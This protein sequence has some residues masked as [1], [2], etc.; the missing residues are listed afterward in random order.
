MPCPLLPL[1]FLLAQQPCV[2]NGPWPCEEA[3]CPSPSISCERLKHNCHSRFADVW[4]TPPAGFEHANVIDQCP[5]SCGKCEDKP[6]QGPASERSSTCVSWRQ[7]A[8][9]SPNGKRQPQHDRPCA[10]QIESGWSGYCE[11]TGGVRAGESTCQHEPFRCESACEKQWEWMRRQREKR[12]SEQDEPFDADGSLSKLYKRGKGFYVM[13]NTELALRH[14]REARGHAA[15]PQFPLITC[16]AADSL[17]SAPLSSALLPRYLLA[18]PPLPSTF[19]LS[20]PPLHSHPLHH[21]RSCI[22]LPLSSHR[23]SS[24]RSNLRALPLRPSLLPPPLNGCFRQIWVALPHVSGVEAGSRAQGVQGGL[25]TSAPPRATPPHPL[26]QCSSI[27]LFT[28]E[29]AG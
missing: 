14:F 27:L 9:C 23:S 13:G 7:T 26:A 29:K 1:F 6:P 11:C 19:S 18:F 5:L 4:R 3:G 28:G 20:T 24:L 25:Q 8:E 16:A 17:P 15:L 2:D 22:C 12:T 21:P 10:Q